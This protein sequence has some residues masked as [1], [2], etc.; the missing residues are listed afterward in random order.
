LTSHKAPQL[1]TI[2]KTYLDTWLHLHRLIREAHK[3][4]M[5]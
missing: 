3:T 2:H 4:K 5:W 1:T